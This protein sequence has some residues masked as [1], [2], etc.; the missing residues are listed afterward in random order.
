MKKFLLFALSCFFAVS[1][2]AAD[3][4]KLLRSQSTVS[5]KYGISSQ[6]IQFEALVK[7]LA[8]DKQ[9]YAHLKRSDGSWVDVPLAY[10][11]AADTGREVWAGSYVDPNETNTGPS[12]KTFDLEFSLR[13]KV[14]G[15]EYWDNNGGQNYKQG[16]DTGSLLVGTNVLARLTDMN[17]PVYIYGDRFS[18]TVTLKNLSSAKQV[19]VL[20]ST[21]GWKTTQTAWGEYSRYIYSGSYSSAQNPNIYG[22]EEWGF[23]LN[24]GAAATKVEYAIAYIVNGTTYWDNN[25]GRNYS[26]PL[27]MNSYR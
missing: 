22:S 26:Q 10:N 4:V 16:R 17:N 12:F 7:N 20:Y 24:V 25:F 11:R 2:W 27:R 9:V 5:S 21:D 18:G 23:T 14:N 13:Y 19:K 6:Y 1:T 15:V 3:E 8:Y